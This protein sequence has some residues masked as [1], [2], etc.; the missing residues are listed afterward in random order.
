M[1][2]RYFRPG[3]ST[4]ITTVE[5]SCP[6]GKIFNVRVRGYKKAA[7]GRTYHQD[8]INNRLCQRCG[9]G[10]RVEVYSNASACAYVVNPD[11]SLTRIASR[12]IAQERLA[13][14]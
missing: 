3:S 10:I 11:T 13:S 14:D 12:I 5:V 2:H 6:C 9:R 1:T 7:P 4:Y 8:G